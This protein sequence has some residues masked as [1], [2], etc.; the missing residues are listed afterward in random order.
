M[1]RNCSSNAI[2][3]MSDVRRKASLPQTP[4]GSGGRDVV[5]RHI[6]SLFDDLEKVQENGYGEEG[7]I[8]WWGLLD[9]KTPKEE[10]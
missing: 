4:S 7:E 8:H 1:R 9:G 3:S 2:R 6:R 5:P 10:M